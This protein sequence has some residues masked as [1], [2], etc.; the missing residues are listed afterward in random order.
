MSKMKNE[1]KN[2]KL[3]PMRHSCEHILHWAMTQLY[4][5]LKRAMGPATEEGFYFDFDFAEKI[6]EEDFPKIEQ[7]MRELI[8]TDS[9]FVKEEL[10]A[11]EA[12]GAFKDNPYK[13]EWIDEAEK[14][15]EKLT[16][17][18]T[19]KPHEK[20][21]DFDLCAGPHVKSTGKIGP[22]K[23]L[24]VAG[25]YWRGSE[26][27]KMLQRIYGTCFETKE[28]LDKYLWQLEEAKRRDH[29]KIGQ[30]LELFTFSE[31]VGPGLPLWLPKGTVI[32]EELEKWAKETEKKLGYQTVSTPH[33]GKSILFKTS[34]HIPYYKDDM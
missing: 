24:S 8:V 14:R 1:L 23:L 29:R 2:D 31:N 13:L 7:K 30:E 15:R 20:G 17:Y 4:P 5:G 22:F 26:K 25:A 11:K 3:V 27:N 28:Q 10:S 19:G 9:P 6:S 12:R 21:S 33:I 16:V 18:W 32:R 34:G